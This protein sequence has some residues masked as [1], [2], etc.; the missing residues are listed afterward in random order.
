MWK[1]S[2]K[3]ALAV[4]ALIA[5][6]M[7]L[8][9]QIFERRARQ[10][11][12]RLAAAR[13]ED[14]LAE[15]RARA[16]TL[17]QRRAELAR[18]DA[19]ETP[20]DQ[21]LPGAVLRRSENGGSVLQH[22]HDTQDEQAVVLARLEESLATLALEMERSDQALRRDLEAIRAEVRREQDASNKTLTLLVAALV[23]LVLHLLISL[24]P[25]GGGEG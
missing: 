21:P 2:W 13:L 9:V 15:S 18:E 14:A 25:P 6:A 3:V 5:T 10:E 12:D 16:E 1:R 11:E 22:V 8:Y 4:I 23:P 19:A 20:G 24:R 7:A 17:E